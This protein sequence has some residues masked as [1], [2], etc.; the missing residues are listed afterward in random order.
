MEKV[1]KGL[2]RVKGTVTS[3]QGSVHTAGRI[4]TAALTG[5]VRGS[6]T[7]SNQLAFRLNNMSVTFKHEDGV[8]L[9][10]GDEVVVVGRIKKGQLEGY[11]LKNLS[12]N[13]SYDHC[14]SFFFYC[15]LCFLPVSLGMILIA[16]GVVLTP[17]ILM[18]L[19]SLH[20][21]KYAARVVETYK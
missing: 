6:I 19:N 13:A 9:Q 20:T 14:N 3:V 18:L 8:G 17:L 11:A 7:S 10:D 16:V 1:K 15:C 4:K 5:N 21:M 12:T 2:V